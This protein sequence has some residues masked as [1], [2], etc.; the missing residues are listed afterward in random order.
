MPVTFAGYA[1]NDTLYD[2]PALVRL[3]PDITTNMLE[4]GDDL[5]FADLNGNLLPYEIEVWDTNATSF[6][7]VLVPELKQNA[8]INAYWGNDQAAAQNRGAEVWYEY[9]GVWH[10]N[11]ESGNAVDSTA[12]NLGGARVNLSRGAG[13]NTYSQ[14]YA[15]NGNRVNVT[16]NAVLNFGSRFT[17]SGWFRYPDSTP[18]NNWRRYFSKKAAYADL[19]GWQVEKR[20][21]THNEFG[22][23]GNGGGN[24]YIAIPGGGSFTDY[25]WRHVT[26]Q[27]RGVNSGAVYVDGVF[28]N[29]TDLGNTTAS[30]NGQPFIIGATLT[31]NESWQGYI[32]EVRIGAAIRSGDWIKAEYDTMTSH[33]FA[34]CG[35]PAENNDVQIFLKTTGISWNCADA[36]LTVIGALA[37]DVYIFWGDTD[38]ED[39]E[40]GWT[41]SGTPT[42]PVLFVPGANPGELVAVLTGLEPNTTYWMR[43]AIDDNSGGY[44]FAPF[45]L[46]FTTASP[47]D[48]TGFANMTWETADILGDLASDWPDLPQGALL[49]YGTEDG[50]NNPAAWTETPV[51]LEIPATGA[52]Q[53]QLAGLTPA[54]RYYAR[55]A[56]TNG[57]DTVWSATSVTFQTIAYPVP[58]LGAVTFTFSPDTTNANVTVTGLGINSKLIFMWDHADKGGDPSEWVDWAN[59]ITN[60]PTLGAGNIFELPGLQ[61]GDYRHWRVVLLSGDGMNAQL[62]G[63]FTIAHTHT[64]TGAAGNGLWMIPGNW[65]IGVVPNLPGSTAILPA[66]NYTVDIAGMGT[67]TLGRLLVRSNPAIAVAASDGVSSLV[68]DNG[69]QSAFVELT[70][71]G[72]QNVNI[73][74]PVQLAGLARVATHL[75]EANSSLGFFGGIKSV[76]GKTG[77]ILMES[78]RFAIGAPAGTTNRVEVSMSGAYDQWGNNQNLYRPRLIIRNS[79]TVIMGG[80][81]FGGFA[82]D[83]TFFDNGARLILSETRFNNF[84]TADMHLFGGSNNRFVVSDGSVLTWDVDRF[85]FNS[86]NNTLTIA[87]ADSQMSIGTSSNPTAGDFM[88]NAS[89]NTLEILDGGYFGVRNATAFSYVR[90]ADTNPNRGNNNTVRIAGAG[91]NGVPARMFLNGRPFTMNGNNCTVVVE[92]DGVL[93]GVAT[94]SVGEAGLSGNRLMPAGGQISCAILNVYAGN[95]LAPLLNGNEILPATPSNYAWFQDGAKVRPANENL[96]TGRFPILKAPAIYIEAPDINSPDFL[97]APDGL[98]YTLSLK[99]E[100]DGEILWLT[101][102]SPETVIIVR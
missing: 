32:D 17:V 76:P 71:G 69:A 47:V 1:G 97:E 24:T 100:P 28:V 30:D 65:D 68:F 22:A 98:K 35:T 93:D 96:F 74:A 18:A 4:N 86:N 51:G 62:S 87:G 5:R 49:Y 84:N 75:A 60:A 56:L 12:N 23:R 31:D 14:Y 78:G 61:L 45:S 33:A 53:E 20:D 73:G 95:A 2:F 64:W 70:G 7:W 42:T 72:V 79:G 66:G 54:T 52:F 26:I 77:S 59:A 10:M 8:V 29:T 55:F 6:V 36:V 67:A 99:N 85:R 63:A 57:A 21:T 25:K 92:T 39:V 89:G 46:N 102:S 3:P 48:T 82:H 9:A 58:T 91:T 101:V 13:V 90:T 37:D 81:V 38:G 34:V 43:F 94:F 15:G 19:N 50:T 27:Y 16:H 44:D 88:L 80:M 41:L 11:E 83:N 40:T